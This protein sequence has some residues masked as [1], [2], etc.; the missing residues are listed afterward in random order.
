MNGAPLKKS[1]A[2]IPGKDAKSGGRE[3][4]SQRVHQGRPVIASVKNGAKEEYRKNK[5]LEKNKP[6]DKRKN[7]LRELRQENRLLQKCITDLQN[8]YDI[9]SEM[10]D[11]A[12][13]HYQ[14]SAE[15]SVDLLFE[16]EYHR[17]K[18]RFI[19]I[20]IEYTP[21]KVKLSQYGKN[22]KD[23]FIREMHCDYLYIDCNGITEDLQNL[24][25]IK[26]KNKK[27]DPA[28]FSSDRNVVYYCDL[29]DTDLPER[30]LGRIIV[31]RYP[32]KSEKKEAIFDRRIKTEITITKRLLEKSIL[33]I[34]NKE[35]AIKDALTGLHSR[36]YLIER[37][38]E[39]YQSMDIL[40]R[41]NPTEMKI[42][43]LIMKSDGAPAPVIKDQFFLKSRTKDEVVFDKAIHRLRSLKAVTAENAR[44]LGELQECYYFKNSKMSYDLYLAMLD[45]DHF[46]DVNDN[47][48]GHSVGDGVLR[49]FAD[50]IKKNIRTTD[51]PVRYGGEEFIIVFPRSSNYSR[52]LTV[53]ENIRT[54]AEK[55]L[56]VSYA[57]KSR[58]VTVSAGVTQMS[59]FDMSIH[60]IINRADSALYR[61]KKHR[62]RIVLCVQDDDGQPV[63]I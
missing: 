41:L 10:F 58:T 27:S 62:N 18:S 15:A 34:Q 61:A 14:I 16:L 11:G 54:E 31:G 52:I 42:M 43:K 50:I 12:Q 48:G 39:E 13:Q 53:L 4:A 26:V 7:G 29:E 37:L 21:G 8:R 38:S 22:I 24:L 2:V 32:Y 63:F 46:K 44:H 20:D 1:G 47:W 60:H 40:S 33:D 59:K 35:L 36:K 25:R 51:I 28:S 19:D 23:F 6:Q 55:K 57:G 45:L 9:L 56:T 5:K 49:S 30:K 17:Y 3:E